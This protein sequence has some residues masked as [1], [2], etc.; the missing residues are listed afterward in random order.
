MTSFNRKSAFLLAALG[1]V[2][3]I[4]LAG[5]GG[6]EPAPPPPAPPPF[7]PQTITVTLGEHGGT[8][9]F[10]TTQAGGFTMNGNPFSSGSTVVSEDNGKTYRV[11]LSGTAG[12]A[13][14]VRAEQVRL[15][16]GSSGEGLFIDENEDGTYTGTLAANF[17]E[18]TF[19]SGE[20]VRTSRGVQYRLTLE[21]GT[22]TA[23]F[24][25]PPPVEITLG[26]SG[27]PVELVMTEDGGYTLNGNQFRSGDIVTTPTDSRYRLTLVDGEWAVRLCSAG[28]DPGLAGHIR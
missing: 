2:L 23:V 25:A 11:T 6:D 9:Q 14:F 27:Y 17:D 13:E 4:G 24:E 26:A 20:L 10:R 18:T 12:T 21:D 19:R 28:P 22:W 7:V 3:L 5:C 1:A 16:L 15:R 8:A